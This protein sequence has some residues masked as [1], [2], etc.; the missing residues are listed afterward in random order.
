MSREGGMI[1]CE[2]LRLRACRRFRSRRVSRRADELSSSL[3]HPCRSRNW[4]DSSIA[5]AGR[6]VDCEKVAV[7]GDGRKTRLVRPE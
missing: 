7:L 4:R 6:K 2:S 3:M 5:T 1:F